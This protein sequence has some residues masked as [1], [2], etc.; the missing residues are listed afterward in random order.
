MKAFS[1]PAFEASIRQQVSTILKN[2]R[3]PPSHRA[4]LDQ[5]GRSMPRSD[6]HPVSFSAMNG[7]R[8]HIPAGPS[9]S[10]HGPGPSRNLSIQVTAPIPSS[11]SQQQ[12]QSSTSASNEEEKPRSVHFTDTSSSKPS[13]AQEEPGSPGSAMQESPLTEERPSDAKFP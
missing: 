3:H 2:D 7:D 12:G 8:F 5:H 13:E 6:R 9:Y 1:D 11:S 4:H 10:G